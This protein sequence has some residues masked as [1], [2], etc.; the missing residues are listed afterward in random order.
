MFHARLLAFVT[1]DGGDFYS[2]KLIEV[3][4]PPLPEGV[5][6]T[7]GMQDFPVL[8]VQRVADVRVPSL[9]YFPSHQLF[10]NFS[11]NIAIKPANDN[12]G[13]LFAILNP[14]QT[15]IS[16]GVRLS[17]VK[18][19]NQ[20]DIQLYYTNFN[21]IADG[22]DPGPAAVFTV[23]AFTGQWKQFSM[24]LNGDQLT[25]YFDCELGERQESVFSRDVT[26]LP[27]DPSSTLFLA[28]AGSLHELKFEVELIIYQNS[29][30]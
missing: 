21:H 10:T 2:V 15:I 24:S 23:P 29:V 9:V 4:G 11:I 7:R 18:P 20:V 1:D 30:D 14:D 26:M 22:I 3:F 6:Y 28:Q 8:E 19:D 5:D 17:P 12:N 27:F 13:M 25:L 16:F